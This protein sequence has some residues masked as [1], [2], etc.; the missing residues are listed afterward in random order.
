MFDTIFG[1]PVHALVVHGVLGLIPLAALAAIAIALVPRWRGRFGYFVLALTT[2]A[3]LAVPVMTQS[4]E[5]LKRRLNAGGIVA[6]QIERHEQAG[7]L[8]LWPVLA[9]WVLTLLVV[10]LHRRPHSQ[11][12]DRALGA[13]VVA[14]GLGAA[15]AVTIAGHLGATAVWSCAIQSDLCK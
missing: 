14:A 15:A 2:A 7:E 1:L 6:K 12:A 8:V 11:A 4:G 13:L 3:L 9:L 5:A 10:F